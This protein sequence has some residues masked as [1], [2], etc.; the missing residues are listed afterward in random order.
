MTLPFENKAAG[1]TFDTPSEGF[2]L[3]VLIKN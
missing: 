1:H 2:Y 3:V